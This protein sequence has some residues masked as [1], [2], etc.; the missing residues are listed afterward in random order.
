MQ[1]QFS[2]PYP[3]PCLTLPQVVE[4]TCR[5]KTSVLGAY[6]SQVSTVRP[7]HCIESLAGGESTILTVDNTDSPL[8]EIFS[9]SYDSLNGGQ[10]KNRFLDLTLRK[11]FTE[12]QDERPPVHEHVS[13]VDRFFNREI[14]VVNVSLTKVLLAGTTWIC[15]D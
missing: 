10:K 11:S 2:I 9:F 6:L 8:A 15:V 3:H 1:R 5:V 14:S 4:H 12:K 7:H 13:L